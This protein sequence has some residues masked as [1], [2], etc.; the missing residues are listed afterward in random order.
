MP[1]YEFKCHDCE[2]HFEV[3]QRLSDDHEADCPDCHAPAQRVYTPVGVTFNGSGFYKT[4]SRAKA[5]A[6]N[7]L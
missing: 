1:A 4:D 3:F 6:A 5:S 2:I 7:T